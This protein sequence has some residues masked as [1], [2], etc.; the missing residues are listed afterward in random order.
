MMGT[1]VEKLQS[2]QQLRSML[3]DYGFFPLCEISGGEHW[4]RGPK[5]VVVGM[6]DGQRIVL[7]YAYVIGE[8]DDLSL[9]FD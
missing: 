3:S 5:R 2:L 4:A 7:M 6:D 9:S 8:G 1:G